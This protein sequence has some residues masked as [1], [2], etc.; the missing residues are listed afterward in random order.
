MKKEVY[1]PEYLQLDRILGAQ[2]LESEKNNHVAH[3]EMLFIIVH[4]TL[5]L[6]M[7][8]IHFELDS[9]LVEFQKPTL[10][11]AQ[12]S[13]LHH[14]LQRITE[15]QK[16]MANHFDVLE[17]MTP[18][19]FLDFRDDLI[20][21]S[22]FQSLQFKQLEKKLGAYK[23][24]T[25]EMRSYSR[26]ALREE[27]R[28]QFE[29]DVFSLFDGVEKWLERNPFL[30]WQNYSFETSF[31]EVIETMFA[32]EKDLIKNHPFLEKE[33]KDKEEKNIENMYQSFLSIFKGRSSGLSKEA[34]LSAL[35]IHF[36]RDH[37]MLHMPYQILRVLVD[38]D[39]N[40][41]AWKQRHLSMVRKMIGLKMGTGG[42]SGQ[43]YLHVS[44]AQSC[45][46]PELVELPSYMI[47]RKNLPSL[48]SDISTELG[49]RW[50]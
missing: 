50:R 14:R 16:L 19:D 41:T 2:S 49:F 26:S 46:F 17:T 13:V 22:G 48:P 1:Y 40:H 28:D 4:Q 33:Q 5:E 35:F 39:Q 3:D 9:V 45:I 23:N 21:A 47:S 37:P 10:D 38:I 30:S 31:K 34:F 36:Y 8:Q 44:I 6:W 42:S 43:K 25:D 32:K 20:P 29:G 24:H 11:D 18:L 7:K 27:E 15:I 12:T